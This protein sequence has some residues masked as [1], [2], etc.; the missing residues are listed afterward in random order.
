MWV[1]EDS[2]QAHQEINVVGWGSQLSIFYFLVQPPSLPLEAINYTNQ[3]SD[4]Y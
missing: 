3:S 4:L 1:G 2:D